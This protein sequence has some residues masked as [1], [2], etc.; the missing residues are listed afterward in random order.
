MVNSYVDSKLL[1]GVMGKLFISGSGVSGLGV[2]TGLGGL[3]VLLGLGMLTGVASS[4]SS[5]SGP[6]ALRKMIA[7]MSKTVLAV[8]NVIFMLNSLIFKQIVWVGIF[9]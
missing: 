6:H 8:G 1:L 7:A 4:S 2:S 9:F 3:G 5:V